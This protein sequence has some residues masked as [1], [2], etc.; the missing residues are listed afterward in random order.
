MVRDEVDVPDL[1]TCDCEIDC[2]DGVQLP[3]LPEGWPHRER[4]W[5]KRPRGTKAELKPPVLGIEGPR[6]RSK[7]AGPHRP[8]DPSPKEPGPMDPSPK[9]PRPPTATAR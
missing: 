2:G 3:T 5:L 7:T 4:P 1:K 9:N 6:G 8:K